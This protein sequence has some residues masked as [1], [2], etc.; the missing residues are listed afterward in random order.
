MTLFSID[1]TCA[2]R[3]HM[4]STQS[5]YVLCFLFERFVYIAVSVVYVFRV[6]FVQ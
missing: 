1:F 5:S 2:V 3:P 6:L 4:M